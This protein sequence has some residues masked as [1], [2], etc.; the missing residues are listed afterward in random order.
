MVSLRKEETLEHAQSYFI[1]FS[2]KVRLRKGFVPGNR[3]VEN[4]SGVS[5]HEPETILTNT[6]LKHAIE[7]RDHFCVTPSQQ[8]GMNLSDV[9]FCSFPDQSRKDSHYSVT[10]LSSEELMIIRDLE[11]SN[12]HCTRH[13]TKTYLELNVAQASFRQGGLVLEISDAV[14]QISVVLHFNRQLSVDLWYRVFMI[15]Q[16]DQMELHETKSNGHT[17]SEHGISSRISNLRSRRPSYNDERLYPHFVETAI[18]MRDVTEDG[19]P[20]DERARPPALHLNVDVT[21]AEGNHFPKMD[22]L[23]HDKC[24]PLCAITFNDVKH[25]THVKNNTYD[26]SWNET[27]TFFVHSIQATGALMAIGTET[28]GP[29][30]TL[31]C[32][33]WNL[34][35]GSQFIGGCIIPLRDV[36]NGALRD[37]GTTITTRIQDMYG[38]DVTG[39]DGMFTTIT[40]KFRARKK[41]EM[42]QI[43]QPPTLRDTLECSE[44]IIKLRKSFRLA[45]SSIIA[46]QNSNFTRSPMNQIEE[47]ASLLEGFD[48]E[49]L[50][51]ESDI[52]WR[53]K[54]AEW[55]ESL[56]VNIFVMSLVVLDSI[57]LIFFQIVN[58]VPDGEPDPIAQ[59]A[60]TVFVLS[61]FVIELSL[62][63]IAKRHQFFWSIWNM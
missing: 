11:T 50:T 48:Q 42:L 22:S 56:T 1:H 45:K 52:Y 17:D 3:A 26:C 44:G 32:F 43:W 27:F 38:V 19:M 25:K 41:Y 2:P 23:P 54:L 10:V 53:E 8:T 60:L 55:M 51:L 59:V 21:I 34:I 62:R 7:D 30:F 49:I 24:D 13:E 9:I 63:I 36:L 40:L 16:G 14:S 58:P 12:D 5:K 61:C 4:D 6:R 46:N 35:A 15:I 28:I 47:E 20:P 31:Q 37:E 57:S 18:E 33:D 29:A 39:F